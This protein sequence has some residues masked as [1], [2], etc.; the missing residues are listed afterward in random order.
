MSDTPLVL[1]GLS[2]Q[3]FRRKLDSG[4]RFGE[5][6]DPAKTD[7][8]AFNARPSWTHDGRWIYF[9]SNK[10]GTYQVWKIPAEGGSAKQITQGGGFEAVEAPDGRAV[11]YTRTY[12]QGT[13][14]WAVPVEGGKETPVIETARSGHW[15]VADQG[16]Y[17]LDFSAVSAA[18][19]KPLK[20]PSFDT[21]KIT[22]ICTIEKMQFSGDASFSVS[23]DGRWAIWLQVDRDESNIML[24]DN[25]R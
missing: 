23:E 21:R 2:R 11:Y 4:R 13:G 5:V 15:A 6:V 12:I 19:P 8:H 9:G 7:D 16:I 22:Q 25:F 24:I 17:F 3:V 14:V 20:F 1:T 18:A 10:S